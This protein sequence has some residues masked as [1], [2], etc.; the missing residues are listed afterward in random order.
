[1]SKLFSDRLSIEK[2]RNKIICVYDRFQYYSLIGL[3]F[4]LMISG[5][6]ISNEINL[7][8]TL[9]RIFFVGL[10]LY[11]LYS[12]IH[13]AFNAIHISIDAW[14]VSVY[15]SPIPTAWPKKIRKDLINWVS[16][17]TDEYSSETDTYSVFC[18]LR[19]G[20]RILLLDRI[21]NHDHARTIERVITNSLDRPQV[22]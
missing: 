4:C 18:I 21:S 17:Q 10:I 1:M 20:K 7:N 13:S 15:S 16:I 3:F 6:V 14:Y 8:I 22:E 9:E 11:I 2:K 12:I 19:D 5:L